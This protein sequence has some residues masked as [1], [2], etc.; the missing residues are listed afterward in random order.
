MTSQIPADLESITPEW[1]TQTLTAAGVI[2][3]TL[4]TAIESERLGEGQGFTGQ[5]IRFR[6]TYQMFKENAPKSIIAKISHPD[7]GLRKELSDGNFYKREINFYKKIANKTDIRTPRCYYAALD[8]ETGDSVLLLED[9]QN[10]RIGDTI[11]GCSGQEAERIAEYLVPLHAAWW[12]NPELE[13][14]DWVRTLRLL[15]DPDVKGN[16]QQHMNNSWC[17]FTGKFADRIPTPIKE[18]WSLFVQHRA[19]IR[20]QAL[21]PPLTLC[22]GDYRLENL[23]FYES[24]DDSQLVVFDWQGL[25]QAQGAFDLSY[26]LILGLEPE[27]RREVEKDLLQNYYAELEKSGVEGYSFEQCYHS[28]RVTLYDLILTRLVGLGNF[29]DVS[30]DQAQALFSTF[31]AKTNEAIIDYPIADLI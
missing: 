31:L 5:V 24:K 15:D 23:F 20:R 19:R 3:G 2:N 26:C 25:I 6:L 4:I 30:D 1:F 12:E 11:R 7:P 10:G 17:R 22:H 29:L 21:V 8:E 16:W 13:S 27:L 9:L 28:Y 14:M 18:A